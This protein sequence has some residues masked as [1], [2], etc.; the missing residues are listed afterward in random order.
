[1]GEAE[2]WEASRSTEDTIPFPA[3]HYWKEVCM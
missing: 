2:Q 3:H 1:M